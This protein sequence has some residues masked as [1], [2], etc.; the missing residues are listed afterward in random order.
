MPTLIPNEIYRYTK[1]YIVLVYT[2]KGHHGPYIHVPSESYQDSE[3]TE[4][5]AIRKNPLQ[6]SQFEEASQEDK[7][8]FRLC[9][10]HGKFVKLDDYRTIYYIQKKT[11]E[12][13]QL[14]EGY[15]TRI[16]WLGG[17]EPVLDLLDASTQLKRRGPF[18]KGINTI[19]ELRE[20]IKT[21]SP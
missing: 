11:G 9:Q 17:V 7:E 19:K 2:D 1:E 8:L 18:V 12:L 5:I 13:L 4:S 3:V 15:G 21:N 16:T 6:L 14:A 20:H 10:Q